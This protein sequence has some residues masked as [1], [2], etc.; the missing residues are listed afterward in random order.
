MI[1]LNRFCRWLFH[2]GPVLSWMIPLAEWLQRRLDRS[3]A[4][5]PIRAPDCTA[6]TVPAEHNA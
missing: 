4:A 2:G 6:P 1:K 3:D 5:E